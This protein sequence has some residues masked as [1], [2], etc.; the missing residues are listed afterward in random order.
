MIGSLRLQ[1]FRSYKDQAFDFGPG[2][3]IIAG[4]NAGGKTNLI[5]S[6]LVILTGSS[7]RAKDLDLIAHNSDWCRLDANLDSGTK[8]SVKLS[9]TT[10]P[11]KV[12]EIDSKKHLRLT[13]SVSWPVILFEPNH[14]RLLQ[15][16]ADRRREYLDDIIRQTDPPTTRLFN[17]YKRT[18]AQRNRLLKNPT[19]EHDKLFPW[20]L[21]LSQLGG[22]IA[23]KRHDLTGKI[24]QRISPV[25]RQLSGKNAQIEMEY[26]KT[27]SHNQYETSFMRALEERTTL[28]IQRGHTTVGPHREDILVKIDNLP[29]QDVA[30]RGEVRSIVLALKVIEIDT[31]EKLLDKKP[32]VLLDD[33]F[34]E[35]DSQRRKA[36]TDHL[37]SHQVFITTTEADIVSNNFASQCTIIS[38]N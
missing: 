1:N 13:P 37:K 33:V 6:I 30:S 17:Q 15:G 36:L 11:H 5:E 18:L 7:Y 35:L 2:V 31:I 9:R 27:W 16:E 21:R 28:D 22:Q 20:N 38:V 19:T 10:K 8:R 23:T 26:Q 25:Y 12:Y 24:N 14:L 4:P 3:N 34:S 29:V 32:V